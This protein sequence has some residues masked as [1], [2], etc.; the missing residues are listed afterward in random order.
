MGKGVQIRMHDPTA[1]MNPALA[2]LAIETAEKEKI[3]HQLAVRQGGGTDAGRIHLAGEG[4]PCVVL[5]VPSR[6]IHSHNSIID[7]ADYRA[8]LDLSVALVR[9]LNATQVRKL[10]RYL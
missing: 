10:T 4:V 1:L 5:G 6:Y 7:L 9:R 2:Q 3:P 8:M